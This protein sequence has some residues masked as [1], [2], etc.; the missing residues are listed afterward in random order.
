MF[1][2]KEKERNAL[3]PKTICGIAGSL[4]LIPLY[5]PVILRR[6]SG[7]NEVSCCSVFSTSCDFAL[8]SSFTDPVMGQLYG[9]KSHGSAVSLQIRAC[10]FH[11][12][13][14]RKIPSPRVFTGF[15][16]KNDR[17]VFPF[18]LTAYNVLMPVPELVDISNTPLEGDM[19]ILCLFGS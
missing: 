5:L 3:S 2:L 16:E 6:R 15:A 11:R 1:S 8:L 4:L 9:L 12:K 18:E 13:G 10:P 14:F 19:G 17:A 7:P